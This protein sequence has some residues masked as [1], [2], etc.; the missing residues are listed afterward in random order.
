MTYKSRIIDNKRQYELRLAWKSFHQCLPEFKQ[1]INNF[2]NRKKTMT[3][4]DYISTLI[5]LRQ[6]L[7]SQWDS[8]I[9]NKS[10]PRII[11]NR[12]LDN[13]V[14]IDKSSPDKLAAIDSVYTCSLRKF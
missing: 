13:L 5:Y 1:A 10:K 2:H 4:L 3:Q 8:S 9:T 12:L 6:K 7:L 14:K 11:L